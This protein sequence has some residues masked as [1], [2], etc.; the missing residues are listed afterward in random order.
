[1]ATDKVT[2]DVDDLFVVLYLAATGARW[3]EVPDS[4][5]ATSRLCQALI[6]VGMDPMDINKR[7]YAVGKTGGQ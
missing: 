7:I 2:V 3:S 5:R 6:A 4:V 1:M